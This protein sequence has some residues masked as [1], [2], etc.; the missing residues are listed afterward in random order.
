MSKLKILD[1]KGSPSGEMELA[2]ELLEMGRGASAVHDAVINYLAS[3]RSGSASTK[4]KAEVAGS[5]KKP[6]RQKGTGRARA[7]YR[8]S[9]IW[10]GGGVAFGP[11]PRSYGKKMNRKVARLAFR[12][13]ISEKIAAEELIVIDAL[14]MNEPKTKAFLELLKN[15]KIGGA[16][17]F[18]VD[19][20]ED[21]VKLSARNVPGIDV[22]RAQEVDVY[23][24]LKYS[25]VVVTKA[26]MDIVAKRLEGTLGEKK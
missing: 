15:L 23:S 9:P 11:K 6:W 17:L 3:A 10:R 13:A 5:N 25:T 7:G 1:V 24:L 16:A 4:T 18:V 8:Q 26:G 19:S 12:R 21:N 14:E 22:V 2:D 20:I